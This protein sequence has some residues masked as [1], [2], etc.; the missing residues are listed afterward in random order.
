ME[1][2]ASPSGQRLSRRPPNRRR[3]VRA[4]SASSVQSTSLV[5][6]MAWCFFVPDGCSLPRP[7]A[8]GATAVSSPVAAPADSSRRVSI[9]HGFPS[10][11]YLSDLCIPCLLSAVVVS[12]DVCLVPL[13]QLILLLLLNR[14]RIIY[15]RRALSV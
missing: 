10:F 3:R 4:P 9:C 2:T 13:H 6:P 8:P 11:P 15:Y 1:G 12:A 5:T 14:T 7:P